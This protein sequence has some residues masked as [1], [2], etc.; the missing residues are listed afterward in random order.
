M[1]SICHLDMIT[2]LRQLD[3]KLP[4]LQPKESQSITKPKHSTIRE[5]SYISP[6]LQ[7]LPRPKVLHSKILPPLPLPDPNLT[8]YH[9]YSDALH[10]VANESNPNRWF[11]LTTSTAP[12]DRIAILKK[13]CKTVENDSDKWQSILMALQKAT[14][15]ICKAN[16]HYSKHEPVDDDVLFPIDLDSVHDEKEFEEQ[17]KRFQK[18]CMLRIVM[19]QLIYLRRIDKSENIRL[20]FNCKDCRYDLKLYAQM[21]SKHNNFDIA[22]MCN[23]SDAIDYDTMFNDAWIGSSG[24][25]NKRCRR[26]VKAIDKH[27]GQQN[28][29]V[30][31]CPRM[32]WKLELRLWSE[33]A[34]SQEYDNSFRDMPIAEY[35]GHNSVL[36]TALLKNTLFEMSRNPKYV[37]ASLPESYKLPVLQEWIKMRFGHTYSQ[38]YRNRKILMSRKQW[39]KLLE[40]KLN[41]RVPTHMDVSTSLEVHYGYRCRVARCV[42]KIFSFKLV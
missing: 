28:V 40:E 2:T 21:A 11:Q 16:R 5:K 25:F 8:P 6:Y 35:S 12:I 15:C 34:C 33:L 24:S 4:T 17:A 1:S 30:S 23:D 19:R 3:K 39:H 36:M 29:I 38:Q 27:A 10:I 7:P 42:S 31:V 37:L 18:Q 32:I 26:F 9:V 14:Y 13:L 22:K 41:V 20:C